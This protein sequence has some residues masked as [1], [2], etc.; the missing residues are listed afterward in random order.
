MVIL[1]LRFDLQSHMELAPG[2]KAPTGDGSQRKGGREKQTSRRSRLTA[3]VFEKEAGQDGGQET[4]RHR[5][6]MDFNSL[7]HQKQ[8]LV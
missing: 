5:C 7:F 1:W 2:K 3:R 6:I 8:Q 4:Q